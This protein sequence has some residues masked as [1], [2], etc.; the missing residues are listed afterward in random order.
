[1]HSDSSGFDD[2]KVA[3]QALPLERIQQV[4]DELVEQRQAGIPRHPDYREPR[5]MMRREPHD[6]G[7]IKIQ[8][9]KATRLR[10]AG[11]IQALIGAPGQILIPNRCRVVIPLAEKIEGSSP[12]VLVQLESHAA[13][14]PDRSTNRS[15]LISAP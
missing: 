8:R 11:L 3:G 7:E 9:D 6:I 5:C 15:R 2:P 1:M 4:G 10:H 14:E 12:E 13:L